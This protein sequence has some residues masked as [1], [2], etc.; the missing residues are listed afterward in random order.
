MNKTAWNAKMCTNFVVS[1]S[2]SAAVGMFCCAAVVYPL[3]VWLLCSEVDVTKEL[4]IRCT[5]EAV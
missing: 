5:L 2:N 4:R 3:V 1:Y